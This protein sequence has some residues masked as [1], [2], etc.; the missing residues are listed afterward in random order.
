MAFRQQSSEVNRGCSRGSTRP[1][2][3][4]R[5]GCVS[6]TAQ[7]LRRSASSPSASSSGC[8]GAPGTRGLSRASYLKNKVKK[9]GACQNFWKAEKRLRFGIRRTVKQ[10][11]FY[12]F[13]IILVFLNTACVAAEHYGQPDWLTKF[14]YY[15]EFIFLGLFITEMYWASLRNLVIS[16]LSSMRSIISLLFLLFLF[17]LIFALLGMQLFGGSFN[18]PEGTPLANFN[19]FA[20]ALLT[21]F[22]ILTGEDWNEVMYNGIASQ[23]G[24]KSGMIYSLYFIILVIFEQLQ[25]FGVFPL[26]AFDG[27]ES[28][29]MTTTGIQYIFSLNVVECPLAEDALPSAR[30]L[31]ISGNSCSAV[32]RPMTGTAVR[33]RN[34]RK[35]LSQRGSAARLALD[36]ILDRNRPLGSDWCLE[37]RHSF[38]LH[39]EGSNARDLGKKERGGA[40]AEQRGNGRRKGETICPFLC[41]LI[42][43][44]DN[45]NKMNSKRDGGKDDKEA[46]SENQEEDMGGPKPMLPYS[47]MFI[48]SPTNPARRSH[49]TAQRPGTPPSHC[50][51]DLST[52]AATSLCTLTPPKDPH[53]SLFRPAETPKEKTPPPLHLWTRTPQR[54]A[55]LALP[56]TRQTPTEAPPSTLR[57][58][59]T[60]KA[61]RIAQPYST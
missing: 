19:T 3:C 2:A 23:G 10:Q 21:V 25:L 42:T 27:S 32:P 57:T 17:I 40:L 44:T 33:L 59:L 13:V 56:V 18:F 49:S 16:L 52:K 54:D 5:E 11:W 29:G 45:E 51:K 43:R 8:C 60:N 15:A 6:L 20:I 31:R 28:L 39:K 50:R 12:W 9:Q 24:I 7:C 38:P 46:E 30:I 22:Q 26:G 36:N 4:W 53:P 55:T 61:P 14:L 48:L 1:L 47:S 41:S 35:G 58:A 37:S 34:T